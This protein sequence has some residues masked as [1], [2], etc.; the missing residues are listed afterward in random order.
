[1]IHN[2]ITMLKDETDP[3]HWGVSVRD[4]HPGVAE[5]AVLLQVGDC[6][7]DQ[8]RVPLTADEAERAAESLLAAAR[9]LRG[10]IAPVAFGRVGEALDRL[11]GLYEKTGQDWVLQV[12]HCL[13]EPTCPTVMIAPEGSNMTRYR[14]DRDTI[15]A[16]ILAS[17]DLVYRE[18]V[19]GET[20]ESE[21]P[22]T[23]PDDHTH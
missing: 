23:N 13:T 2:A 6:H 9:H 20:I 19:L 10:G 21:C 15:E 1:M 5:P 22:F 17:A 12:S 18:M 11:S 7:G 14:V 4:G 3:S 8:A 16:G